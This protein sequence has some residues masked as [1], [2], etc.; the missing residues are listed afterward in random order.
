M[1]YIPANIGLGSGGDWYDI[2]P[3]AGGRTGIVVG[4]IAGHGIEAAARMAQVRATVNVLIRLHADDISR[5][6]P[7]AE[8]L[9]RYLGDGYIATLAIFA[10]DPATD[11]L[12]YVSAGHPAAVVIDSDGN[13]SVLDGGRRPL[14]GSGDGPTDVGRAPFSTGLRL[15]AFTDG[16]VERRD[17]TPDV[18]TSKLIALAAAAIAAGE[19]QLGPDQLADTLIGEMLGPRTARDDVA[20]VVAERTLDP[21]DANSTA[22]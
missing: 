12:T 13:S 20:L 14:L 3:L 19:A 21:A 8:E 7:E 11:T 22:R 6:V 15:I 10:I 18:G 5:V 17:R 16:L 9:L 4:D 1:R 2:T